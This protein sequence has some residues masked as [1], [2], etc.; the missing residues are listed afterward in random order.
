MKDEFNSLVVNKTWTMVE[1]GSQKVLDNKWVFKRKL[2]AHGNV[3]RYKARLVVR[4]F[5]QQHGIDYEDTFSPTLRFPSFRMILAVAAAEKLQVQFFDIKTAFL[6]GELKET[7][8][9]KQPELFSDGTTNVC[10]L[11]RSLY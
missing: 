3:E 6:N 1:R 7:V 8:V 4:G 5:N 9:M 2:D 10:L 11:R